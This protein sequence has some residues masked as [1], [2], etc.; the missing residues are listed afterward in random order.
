M[1]RIGKGLFSTAYRKTN[2][3]VLIKSV[4]HVKEC[5]AHGWFPNSHLFPKV[6]FG[7]ND[8][9]YLMQYYPRMTAP[10]RQ[11]NSKH[12]AIYKNLRA[13]HHATLYTQNFNQL[14]KAFKIGIQDQRVKVAMIEAL[15][16]CANYGF[17]IS[18]EISPRN[19]SYTPTGKL[20][21]M[22]CF[23]IQSQAR[24]IRYG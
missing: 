16:A 15:E 8:N 21:L 3:Q 9:E 24:I 4:D 19:V 18:F 17:D 10:S 22:D 20:V 6:R 23:F 5:M 7:D 14:R 11:L 13:I 2:G 1:E 12:L